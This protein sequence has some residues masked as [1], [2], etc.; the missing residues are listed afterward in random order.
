MKFGKSV[1]MKFGKSVYMKFGKSGRSGELSRQECLIGI[2][3]I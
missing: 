1:Y 3:A 2:R